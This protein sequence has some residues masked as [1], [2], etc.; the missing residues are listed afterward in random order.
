[1]VGCTGQCWI[2]TC[3]GSCQGDRTTET[4]PPNCSGYNSCGGW[5]EVFCSTVC[6]YVACKGGCSGSGSSGAYGGFQAT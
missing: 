6:G 1:M 3:S 4:I 5:C 2:G